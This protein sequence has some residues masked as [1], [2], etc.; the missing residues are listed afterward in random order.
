M[1]KKVVL[2]GIQPSGSP[3]IGN[4][5][6]AIKKY[7]YWAKPMSDEY[8]C[9]YF[10]ADLHA[11]TVSCPAEELR[12]NTLNL[13][14]TLLACG[15]EHYNCAL[16]VQSH[17]PAHA[18]LNWVLNCFTMFGEAKRMAQFKDKASKSTDNVNVGLFSYPV[19]Q[20][21]DILL[22]QAD[23]VPVGQDQKQHIELARNLAERFNARYSP[24]FKLPE[25]SIPGKERGAKIMSLTEPT[26]KM[27]KS[28]ENPNS[29][30][31][32][33]DPPEVIMS[34]FKRAVTDSD[35]EIRYSADKPGVSN[36]LSIY[37]AFKSIT[38]NDAERAFF[39]KSY[40]KFKQEVAE[41]V[42]EEV[43]R[44]Q[45]EYKRLT[46]DKAYLLEVLKNGAEKANK[47]ARK[48]LSK[49]YRKIGLV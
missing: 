36:L 20:A 21:A 14:A 45:G 4:Y 3:T 12:K 28:D 17:V 16:F 15:L 9:Y 49:V 10:L 38:V 47:T 22:Y 5:L 31:L 11:L 48:T 35:N 2:S 40:A 7:V 19:L 44:I 29:Y 13:A 42:I 23:Y 1:E 30:I 43:K 37:A 46:A 8:D 27:S 34:K 32:L 24:T 26:K 41:V 39:G 25:P 6:G 33:T 18:E